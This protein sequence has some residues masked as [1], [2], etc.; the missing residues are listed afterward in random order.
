MTNCKDL[1]EVAHI[2]LRLTIRAVWLKGLDKNNEKPSVKSLGSVYRS[3]FKPGHLLNKSLEIHRCTNLL[4]VTLFSLVGRYQMFRRH[5][6][7]FSFRYWKDGGT[8]FCR[9]VATHALHCSAA[10]C[11]LAPLD[12]NHHY[13]VWRYPSCHV[14]RV[15]RTNRFCGPEGVQCHVALG[16]PLVP[17][18]PDSLLRV[19]KLFHFFF[20][21]ILCFRASQYKTNET[22]TWCNT[23]QVLFL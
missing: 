9:N 8:R 22:P 7:L 10:R 15:G 12:A 2:L 21:L 11:S 16:Q 20:F 18:S 5:M 14:G 19:R 17:T 1:E 23:V 4:S 13:T 6:V 3:K